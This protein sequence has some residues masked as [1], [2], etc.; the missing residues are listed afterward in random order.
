MGTPIRAYD[1]FI[2]AQA[3]RHQAPL[4]TANVAEFAR[5]SGL[6][7]EDWATALPAHH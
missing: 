6:A 1:L 7:F 3:L 2:A 5:V 4:I